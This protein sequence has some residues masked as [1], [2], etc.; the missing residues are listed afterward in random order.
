MSCKSMQKALG[1]K[2]PGLVTCKYG[3]TNAFVDVRI[4]DDF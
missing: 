1:K 4:W 3:I 2:S